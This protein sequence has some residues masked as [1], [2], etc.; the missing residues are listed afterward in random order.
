MKTA[1]EITRKVRDAS[2]GADEDA[3]GFVRSN[4]VGAALGLY[5]AGFVVGMI[6]GKVRKS[7]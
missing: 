7:A 2:T 1:T 5:A 4:P 6:A 3:V